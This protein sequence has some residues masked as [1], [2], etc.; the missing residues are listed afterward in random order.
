MAPLF[1]QLMEWFMHNILFYSMFG[2]A[3]ILVIATHY[4]DIFYQR[5]A[6]NAISGPDSIEMKEIFLA[7]KNEK[8]LKIRK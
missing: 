8:H 6:K 1:G 2:L 3:I 4:L 5:D 7:D